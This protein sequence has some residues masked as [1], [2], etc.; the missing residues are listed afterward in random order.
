[1]AWNYGEVL[2]I[3]AEH[4]GTVALVLAGHDHPG[5]YTKLHGAHFVTLEAILESPPGKAAHAVVRAFPDT[6][7]IFAGGSATPRSLPLCPWP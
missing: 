1:M 3:L 7:E 5:G 4:A 2:G 6:V